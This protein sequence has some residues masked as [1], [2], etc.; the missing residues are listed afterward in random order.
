MPKKSIL[1]SGTLIAVA[2]LALGLFYFSQTRNLKNSASIQNPQQGTSHKFVGNV[3][4][5]DGNMIYLFGHYILDSSGKFSST[6]FT[7]KIK[8]TAD[9]NTKFK[10]T[11]I[12]RT[13]TKPTKTAVPL[14]FSKEKQ[15][16]IDDSLAGF[17]KTANEIHGLDLIVTTKDNI[18]NARSFNADTISYTEDVF[19]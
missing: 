8:I 2:I 1:I 11:V 6:K 7:N 9:N 19:Q 12:H 14:D 10:K 3:E 4:K 18:L 15:E 5:I 16:I 13:N 17:Q